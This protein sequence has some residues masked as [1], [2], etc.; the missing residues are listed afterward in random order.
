MFT[1]LEDQG[2]DFA[3]ILPLFPG[4]LSERNSCARGKDKVGIMNH[5]GQ[6][7]RAKL[8]ING[9]E[10]VASIPREVLGSYLAVAD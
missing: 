8:S 9:M 7:S 3:P 2:T 4:K 1:S 10:L 5:R 6:N